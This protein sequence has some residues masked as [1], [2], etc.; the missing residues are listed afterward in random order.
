MKNIKDLLVDATK[1]PAAI[2]ARLPEAFP[3]ISTFLVDAAGRIPTVPDFP[4]DVPPLPDIPTL[5]ETPLTGGLRRYITGVEVK[6]SPTPARALAISPE[7]EKVP[8]LFE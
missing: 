1:Y 8:L 2:E 5:P 3:K 7:R 4:V 6:P